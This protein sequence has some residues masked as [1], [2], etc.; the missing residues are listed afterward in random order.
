MN[1][2]PSGSSHSIAE[3]QERRAAQGASFDAL[4]LDVG[5]PNGDR[6]AFCVS[7]HKLDVETPIL[8]LTGSDTEA[9]VVQGLVDPGMPRLIRFGAGYYFIHPQSGAV[10]PMFY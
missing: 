8:M 4:L 3:V 2:R 9:D 1:R 10:T 6:G 7:L 5:L